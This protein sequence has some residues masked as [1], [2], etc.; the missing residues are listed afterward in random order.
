MS[1]R[2]NPS[3]GARWM[4]IAVLLLVGGAVSCGPD[5]EPTASAVPT[6]AATEPALATASPLPTPTSTPAPLDSPAP[7]STH[8][9]TPE[10][11]STLPPTPAD[12]PTPAPT[13]P[14]V[15]GPE[16]S[17]RVAAFYYPWYRT[18]D[19]DGAWDHWGETN[20]RPPLDIASD[21][22]PLLGAY[23]NLDPAVVARHFAWLREAGIGVIVSSWW[24]RMSIEEKAVPLLLDMGARYGIQVA[25][26]MEPYGGRTA[27]GLVSDVRYLYDN[28][29]GHPAFY[30]TTA[31]SRWSQD[32][33][34]K[35]LFF[36]WASLV[37]DTDSLP[38]EP[39]YWREALDTIH[40]LPDGG[41]VLSDQTVSDW[42]DGGHFDGLYSYAALQLDGSYTWARGLPPGAW[43]VPGVN[44]GF[45]AVRIRYPEDTFVPRRDGASY[46]ER[47]AAALDVGVEP[48]L[49]AVTSFNEWHEGT[50]IEP[51]AVGV[52]NGRGYTYADYSPLPPD[53]Y[54]ALTRRWVDR[55]AA[56][57]WPAATRVRIRMMTTSDWTTL[58]LIEGATWLRPGLVSASGEALDARMEG[59]RLFLTQPL[60][61]AEAGG[62]V[63]VTVDL[64]F[65]GLEAGGTLVFEI[66]R[67]HLGFTQVE[68]FNYVGP[69]P[70]AVQ[71]FTWGDIN[72]GERNAATFPVPAEVLLHAKP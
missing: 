16:P 28:Y 40:A 38:V 45:S 5:T 42:V 50:Q 39:G 68:L 64:L 32:D 3:Q 34:A 7:T 66:E 60:D 65:S 72:P 9:P 20:F 71:A 25:F 12:S 46:D 69:E 54:L 59:D 18:P 23:S 15:V 21:Y 58:G 1:H 2:Q 43:Y 36:L 14:P 24:G 41:L 31:R 51:A 62:V 55:V 70:V 47:W 13:L 57:R 26:H 22:Y 30:R 52:T 56:M 29:G 67:G 49:V 44:P 27:D 11:T 53:G 8:T 37:P 6:E 35:G 4:V 10:P 17:L 19:F 63:D 48:A 33:R 61:R